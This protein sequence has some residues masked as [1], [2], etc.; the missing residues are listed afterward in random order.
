MTACTPVVPFTK[1]LSENP[2]KASA[3]LGAALAYLGIE[4]SVPLLHGS[5][6]CTSF[7]LVLTVRHARE[8]IPLQTTA[9]DEVAAILGGA[10]NLEQALLNLTRRMKPRFIGIASTALSATRGE[11]IE[12]DLN[13]IRQRQPELADVAIA[14]AATPG[15]RRRAGG[16]LVARGH[17]HYRRAGWRHR[18][19]CAWCTAPERA[20]RR[21]PDRRGYRSDR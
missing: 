3:P 17:R 11:D 10:D 2:L 13:L 1:A 18:P 14:F 21:A 9:L 5:Q 12:G 6:G 19:P 15:L 20:G 8:A 16:W 7:A 4:G